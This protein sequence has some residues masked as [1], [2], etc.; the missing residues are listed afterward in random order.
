MDNHPMQFTAKCSADKLGIGSYSIKRNIHIAG[1]D[2][3]GSIIEGY[4]ISVIIMAEK[5]PVDTQDSLVIAENIPE[6]ADFKTVTFS[7][8]TKPA[9]HSNFVE[10]RHLRLLGGEIDIRLF[11]RYKIIKTC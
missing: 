8:F 11:H 2:T 4:Y 9:T 3:A 10:L 1:N 6:S 7:H 5:L